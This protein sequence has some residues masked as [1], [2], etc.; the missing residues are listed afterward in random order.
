MVVYERVFETVFDRETQRLFSKWSLTGGGRLREVVAR[1]ELTVI[2]FLFRAVITS[3]LD[4]DPPC[5]VVGGGGGGGWGYTR[6]HLYEKPHG[7]NLLALKFE[8]SH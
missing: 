3:V 2:P 8:M 7:Q 1:R 4:E 5:L 6:H